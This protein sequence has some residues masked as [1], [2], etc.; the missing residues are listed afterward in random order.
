MDI[1]SAMWHH[2]KNSQMSIWMVHWDGC[3]SDSPYIAGANRRGIQRKILVLIPLNIATKTARPTN[4]LHLSQ[5]VIDS[6]RVVDDEDRAKLKCGS[7]EW[8]SRRPL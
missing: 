6:N 1:L 5:A 4:R 2:E 3:A 8:H 7:A